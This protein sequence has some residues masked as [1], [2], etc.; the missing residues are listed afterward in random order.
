MDQRA[1]IR[2]EDRAA[3]LSEDGNVVARKGA[4]CVGDDRQAPTSFAECMTSGV[5]L[6]QADSFLDSIADRGCPSQFLLIILGVLVI[7]A[8]SFLDSIADR[9]YPS[10]F[11]S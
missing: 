10:Q 4:Y 8:D 3:R 9:G 2:D 6:S 11:H 1:G 7:E 5:D